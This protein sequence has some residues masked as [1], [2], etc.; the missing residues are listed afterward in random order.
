MGSL[1]LPKVAGVNSNT[2]KRSRTDMGKVDHPV[3]SLKEVANLQPI[4]VES[5]GSEPLSGLVFR[6][7]CFVVGDTSGSVKVFAR[8]KK[9]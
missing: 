9:D 5:V 3:A 4:L 7:D 6:E 1:Y 8:P 2:L